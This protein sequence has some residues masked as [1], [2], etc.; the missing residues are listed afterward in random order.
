MKIIPTSKRLPRSIKDIRT[1]SGGSNNRLV[2]HKVYMA[3]MVLEMERARRE[4]EQGNL[5]E[6]LKSI[7][8]R[9]AAIDSEKAALL[10]GLRERPR[11]QALVV[12]P[13]PRQISTAPRTQGGFKI[14]Y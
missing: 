14:R 11:H 8:T 7:E 5:L 13:A 10:S 12:T 3:V 4:T 1:R 9:L 2:P 6:R